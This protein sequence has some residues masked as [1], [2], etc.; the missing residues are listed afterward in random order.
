MMGAVEFIAECLMEVWIGRDGERHGPYKEVD[1]RQWLRSGQLSVDDLGWYEGMTDWQ[2]LSRL[3]P[4]ERGAQPP[5]FTPPTADTVPPTYTRETPTLTSYAG[6]WKRL[7]AYIL[8]ALVLWIPNMLL[9]SLL[10]ANQAAEVYLQAKLAAGNDPQLALQALDA[11]FSAMG[12]ALLAQTVVG[13]L[14]F[15]ACE[16]SPWQ[17]TLGK[18][19]LGIRVTDLQG[20]RISFVRATGRYFGKL[21]SAF[22]LCIG[23]L[24]VAWTQRKQGLHDML[25]QTLVLNGRANEA[26]TTTRDPQERNSSI[27]A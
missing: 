24:M 23:F 14:Y 19:A 27:N 13:W 15:A 25:A 2:P 4:D 18:L 17:A 6:F 26:P 21:L 16:S 9:G 8:D 7:G 3:F 10:G 1:V 20:Q 22:M 5:A 12:P 11:Y